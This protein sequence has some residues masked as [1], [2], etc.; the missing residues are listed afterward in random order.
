MDTQYADNIVESMSPVRK[1]N[2]QSFWMN[3]LCNVN[4][5]RSREHAEAKIQNMLCYSNKKNEAKSIQVTSDI[6]RNVYHY[7]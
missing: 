1:W 6:R 3:K 7:C 5:L 2:K 4:F